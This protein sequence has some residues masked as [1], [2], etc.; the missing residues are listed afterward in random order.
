[1]PKGLT[2]LGRSA[3]VLVASLMTTCAYAIDETFETEKENIRVTTMA[4]GL[5]NPWGLD[6]L[7]DGRMI[8][9]EK[10]GQLRL[11]GREGELSDP[12]GGV[13]EV[14]ARGQGGLLD[15]ALH[16]DFAQNR[17]VYL[18]YAEP[19]PDGTNSTAAARG[20]LNE[21]ETALTDVEVIFRQEP[22]LPSTGHYG[23][24]LVFDGEGQIFITTGERQE[25]EFAGQAQSLGSLLGKV[26]RLNEDGSVPEDNPFFGQDAARS[27]IWSLGHRN[28]QSAAMHPQS[29]RLW[30]V[31]HGPRG[32]DEI[33]IPW[34]GA[35]Y[36]WPVVS[37][38]I[39]YDGTPVGSGEKDAPGMEDPIVT[40]TPV[41]APSGMA[42]YEGDK[43][44]A[45]KGNLFIGG[46]RAEA[47]VRLELDGEKVTHEERL[48]ESLG[49]RIRDVTVGP[50]GDL[51][52]LTDETDGQIL[53]IAPAD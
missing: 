35:N 13:P 12:L 14:D 5:V 43:F 53:R 52:A 17:L 21:D 47:L 30:I 23:S 45:W 31:E 8:V 2:I 44:P 29:R 20:K 1:M 24:R 26:V 49:Q 33:N 32:G 15:V 25:G 28:I 51:Y 46:L 50:D 38:G 6:F 42:F 39:N 36:G 27:E 48:L 16:P 4:D 22:K 40:W 3:V 18:T 19:G 7:P 41:I 11:V 9:T 34:P 37:H 10:S